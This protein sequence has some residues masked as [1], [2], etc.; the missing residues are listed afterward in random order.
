M[1]SFKPLKVIFF[2]IFNAVVVYLIP[3]TISFEAWFLLSLLIV[4]AILINFEYFTNKFYAMKWIL[5]G[6]IFMISFVVFPAVYNTFVSFTNWS[7]GHILN[8][9]QA[10]QILE[11]RTYTPE[12]QKG[13]EFDIYVMQDKNFDFYF[14]AN[15][16][17]EEMYFGK[18][19]TQNEISDA[20]PASHEP[21]I[22]K[23]GKVTP[24][25]DLKLL[26]GKDQIANSSTLQDLSLTILLLDVA[27]SSCLRPRF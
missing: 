12:D 4:N 5:P 27:I 7:T 1:T 8:K 6:M 23:D 26:S 14:F 2:S 10:I 15:I 13:F 3:L 21:A 17:D 19:V 25:K 11:N 22:F 24:P 16:S 20:S 18:A 9:T